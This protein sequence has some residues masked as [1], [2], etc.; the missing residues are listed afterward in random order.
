MLRYSLAPDVEHH[1]AC[2]KSNP[3]NKWWLFIQLL[4]QIIH[5]S[6]AAEVANVGFLWRG[7]NIGSATLG[8]N[9]CS[10][11]REHFQYLIR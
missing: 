4:T 2:C 1:A 9:H 10:V 8:F 7:N 11:Q 3:R 5:R 6:A